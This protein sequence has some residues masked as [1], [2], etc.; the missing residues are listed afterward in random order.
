MITNYRNT[1]GKL[2][3]SAEANREYYAL[4]EQTEPESGEYV[5]QTRTQTSL[6]QHFL[7]LLE[8]S[9]ESIRIFVSQYHSLCSYIS[10]DYLD[11]TYTQSLLQQIYALYERLADISVIWKSVIFNSPVFSHYRWYQ[12]FASREYLKDSTYITED[13]RLEKMKYYWDFTRKAIVDELILFDTVVSFITS[14][15]NAVAFCLDD[16]AFPEHR[17]I[18]PLQRAYLYQ[19]LFD[20]HFMFNDSMKVTLHLSEPDPFPPGKIFTIHKDSDT[21]KKQLFQSTFS[22][23]NYFNLFKNNDSKTA[24]QKYLQNI[25]EQA[26]EF[27]FILDLKTLEDVYTACMYSFSTLVTKDIHIHRCK[28]CKRYFSP[29]NRT[30][31]IYCS[32]VW[33]NGKKCRELYHEEKLAA[34]Q[35]TKYYR[36]AYKSQNAKKQRNTVN[37]PSSVKNF[38][39]WNSRAKEAL[40]QAKN[41]EITFEEFKQIIDNN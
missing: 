35:L 8:S 18:S 11:F 9:K 37:K 26:T 3:I 12:F 24:Y 5:C 16:D 31:E 14:M 36:S 40:R 29:Y 10:R 6:G 25:D 22:S 34:D 19:S 4:F 23:K 13:L 20:N 28:R 17:H 33:A 38:E 30:D 1:I 27:A 15:N 2:Y 32:H 41:N 7:D 39:E 21:P